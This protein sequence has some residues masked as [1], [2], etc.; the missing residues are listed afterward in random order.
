V[1]ARLRGRAGSAAD[2]TA[3]IRSGMSVFVHGAAATPL[4]LLDALCARTDLQ[5]VT[6]YHLHTEGPAGFAAPEQAGRLHSVSL[7]TGASL[8]KPVEEGRADFTPVFLSQIPR[9]FRTRKIPLDV[10]LVQLSPPDHH[11]LCSLGTS[12]DTARAA[13]D[14]AVIVIAEI[15]RRMPRTHGN[16]VVPL[17]R[18]TAWFETDRPLPATR[19]CGSRNRSSRWSAIARPSSSGSARSPTPCSHA[20]VTKATWA[21]TPRCS[22]MACCPCSARAW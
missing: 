8:R 14:S 10:A 15:N 19:R 3:G 1:S 20:S 11:G 5:G 17:E 7:F 13:V 16:A 22:P 9:L 18:L 12:V 6:L 4:P 2:A 21:S